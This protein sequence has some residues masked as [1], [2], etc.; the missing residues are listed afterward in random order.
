MSIK[1]LATATPLELAEAVLSAAG[2]EVAVLVEDSSE[3]EV[4]FANNT[5]TSV[6]RRRLRRVSVVKK[7]K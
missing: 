1:A 4:R 6:G 3:V 7:I 5:V 2:G